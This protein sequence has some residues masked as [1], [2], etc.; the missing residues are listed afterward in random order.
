VVVAIE[1][2]LF[3]TQLKRCGNARYRDSAGALLRIALA[4]GLTVVLLYASGQAWSPVTL[5]TVPALIQGAAVGLLA[6]L[7]FGLIQS[8]LWWLANRPAGPE[9]RILELAQGFA[10]RFRSRMPG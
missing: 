8:G 7:T 4:T 3:L 6:V 2:L 9:T 10:G 5:A 1:S